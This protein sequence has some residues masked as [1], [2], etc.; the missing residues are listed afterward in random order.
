[1]LVDGGALQHIGARP[2]VD[3]GWS[4]VCCGAVGLCCR[5]ESRLHA[6]KKHAFSHLTAAGPRTKVMTLVVG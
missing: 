6:I 1:M 4:S 2:A 3:V 5:A